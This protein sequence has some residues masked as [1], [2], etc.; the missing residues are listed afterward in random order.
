LVAQ[1]RDDA[2]ATLR[3]CA[4]YLQTHQHRIRYP[5]FRAMG[6]PVGSGVVEG[7][8]NH[9]IGLRFK[10]KSTRWKKPGGR[11]VLRLRV[12]RLSARWQQRCDL[13]RV[14]A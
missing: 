9:V 8:C 10:R 4:D 14:A 6:W 11:A 1:G 7:A 3:R 2:R 12:D 13:M 5:L